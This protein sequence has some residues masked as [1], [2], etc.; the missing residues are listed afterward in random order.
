MSSARCG[1]PGEAPTRRSG[2][3]AARASS[4]GARRRSRPTWRS[5]SSSTDTRVPSSRSWRPGRTPRRHTTS[6]GDGRSC[7]GTW[8]SWTSEARSA[9]TTPTPREP[10]WSASRRRGSTR[11]T[12]WSRRRRMRRCEPSAR[13]SAA[14]DVDRAA[15]RIIDAGGYGERFFHRTGHGIGLEIHEP[16]YIIEGNETVLTP[17]MTFSVEPGDLPGGTVRRPDRGHRGRDRGRR[18][19]AEPLHARAPDRRLDGALRRIGRL[20]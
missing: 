4:G 15:R 14:Q 12:G 10:W 2:R 19:P 17:G 8:S 13:A 11:C 16:P 6:R 7:R 20:G 5:C 18:R 9:A 1:G 3:S